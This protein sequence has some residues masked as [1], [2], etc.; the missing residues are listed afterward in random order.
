MYQGRNMAYA[1][2]HMRIMIPRCVF[3]SFSK[4]TTTLC[5]PFKAGC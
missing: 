3:Q 1:V 2:W 5:R 4:S